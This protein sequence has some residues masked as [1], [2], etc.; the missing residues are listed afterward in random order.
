MRPILASPATARSPAVDDAAVGTF[1][2][3]ELT[4]SAVLF[5]KQQPAEVNT[6][7]RLLKVWVRSLQARGLLP[8]QL[9]PLSFLAEMLAVCGHAR[10]LLLAGEGGTAKAS[11]SAIVKAALQQAL[12][13]AQ[14]GSSS[15]P[16][17]GQLQPGS[18]GRALVPARDGGVLAVVVPSTRFYT[19]ADVDNCRHC[20]EGAGPGRAVLLHPVDPTDSLLQGRGWADGGLEQLGGEA[21]RVLA[22][23]ESGTLAELMEA[24]TLGRAYRDHLGV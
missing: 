21:A 8:Q 12:W 15:Q 5:M 10:D 11:L 9:K 18:G 13:L 19:P 23:M 3:A 22:A 24:S 1:R 6:A 14:P 16:A 17:E 4:E 2:S 7:A 20:W